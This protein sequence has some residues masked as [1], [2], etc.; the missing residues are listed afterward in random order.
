MKYLI[1]N[2]DDFG[3]SRG[4]NHGILEA[5]RHG[6]LT[7]ASLM[8][9]MPQS[10]DAAWLSREAPNLSVG[11][12]VNFTNEAAPPIVDLTD[13]ESCRTELYRQ[14]SRFRELMGSL[15]THLDSHHHVH[16]K[17][18][19]LPSFLDLARKYGLPLREHSPIRYFP[20]FYGQWKD[21]THPDWISAANLALL[22][23]T[24]IPDG[25]TE[26]GCHVGYVDPDFQSIYSAE[27]ELE[28][29]T[30]CD[31]LFPL[32]LTKQQIELISFREVCDRRA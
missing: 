14:F 1:V 31:P 19:L 2:A 27:R 32:L 22:L 21:G 23:S 12:H 7:S 30:I 3:A 16:R 8:V 10:E 5:H 9:N 26:L 15:P 13:P 11:L 29:Q 28:L 20:K 4:I 17:P 24:E 25:F 6:I 18:Q